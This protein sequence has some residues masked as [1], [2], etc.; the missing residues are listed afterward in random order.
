M[1]KLGFR[2]NGCYKVQG[3]R[4]LTDV[5]GCHHGCKHYKHLVPFVIFTLK[6]QP[7]TH[8]H[9]SSCH[10]AVLYSTRSGCDR[11]WWLVDYYENTQSLMYMCII[12]CDNYNPFKDHS[13][14]N[15]YIFAYWNLKLFT[16]VAKT[17]N[18]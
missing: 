4:H 3:C 10:L 6:F 15:D 7:M 12:L 18:V 5:S 13:F 11:R 2:Q 16:Y 9:V 14:L 1:A 17:V 8:M